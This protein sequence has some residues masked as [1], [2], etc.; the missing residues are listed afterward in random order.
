MGK[1]EDDEEA[2][3]E[4]ECENE[5]EDE[6]DGEHEDEEGNK[7]KRWRRMNKAKSFVHKCVLDVLPGFPL[8]IIDLFSMVVSFLLLCY[9]YEIVL[10]QP[11]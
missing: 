11:C 5:E 7:M 1:D 6:N 2:D 3:G 8:T 9:V 10:M 4:D